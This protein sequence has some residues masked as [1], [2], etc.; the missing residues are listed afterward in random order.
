MGL[1]I[2]LPTL[3]LPVV[4]HL[5]G[6]LWLEATPLATMSSGQAF[7]G[8]GLGVGAGGCIHEDVCVDQ[9]ATASKIVRGSLWASLSGSGSGA[10]P[11]FL[12][13]PSSLSSALGH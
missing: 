3:C 13:M 4:G 2:S 1:S 8:H 12:D 7:R 11:S 9:A 10:H 5:R 6:G